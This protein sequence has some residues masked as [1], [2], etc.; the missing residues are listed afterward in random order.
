[1][2]YTIKISDFISNIADAFNGDY[3]HKN[4]EL[5]RFRN[6]VFDISIIPNSGDDKKALKTDFDKFL[7]DTRKA[8]ESL[9]E[10]LENG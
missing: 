7:K 4:E 3:D 5:R 1:M 10:E 6:E 8:H 2:S 9:K